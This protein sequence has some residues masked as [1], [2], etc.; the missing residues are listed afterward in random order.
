MNEDIL[1]G[2]WKLTKAG[3]GQGMDGSQQ[4]SKAR[5]RTRKMVNVNTS[6]LRMGSTYTDFLI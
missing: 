6:F 1:G 4:Q 3:R 5:E 2:H